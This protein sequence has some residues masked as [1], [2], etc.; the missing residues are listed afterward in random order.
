MKRLSYV[1]VLV[2]ALSAMLLSACAGAASCRQFNFRR[3]QQAPG[4]PR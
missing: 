3:R 2:L 1:L 4:K